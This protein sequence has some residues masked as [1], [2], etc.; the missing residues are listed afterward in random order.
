MGHETTWLKQT[1][2]QTKKNQEEKFIITGGK[3]GGW[4]SIE[5]KRNKANRGREEV[6][7]NQSDWNGFVVVFC[8]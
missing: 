5:H 2:K 7:I 3:W 1:N 8:V 4:G 6:R